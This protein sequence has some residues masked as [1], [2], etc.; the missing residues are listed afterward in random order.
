L[1]VLQRSLGLRPQDFDIHV[2]FPGGVP[3]DGP[4]AG[5]TMVTAIYSALTGIPVDPKVVMTGEVSIRGHV[6]PVGGVVAK[7]EAARLAGARLALIPDENWQ[8]MFADIEGMQVVPVAHIDEVIERTLIR[9]S[10]PD[11]LVGSLA[12]TERA[13]SE[14]ERE[15]VAASNGKH[16]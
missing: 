12:R 6:R 7:L 16:A 4:S 11:A 8:E 2:N 14:M 9:S 13:H 3:V 1:T 5:V 15:A 10:A